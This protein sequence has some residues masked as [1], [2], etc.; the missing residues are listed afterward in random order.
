VLKKRG[1]IVETCDNGASAI[2]AVAA[3]QFDVVLMDIHMPGMDGFE[4]VRRIRADTL[5]S[6]ATVP[7]VAVTAHALPGDRSRCLA[8]GMDEYVAK[9][10]RA[11]VLIATIISAVSKRREPI[12]EVKPQIALADA[13]ITAVPSMSDSSE[14]FSKARAYVGGNEETFRRVASRL[15]VQL[16]QVVQEIR[17]GQDAAKIQAM[18]HRLSGSWSLF[19]DPPG[20]SLPAQIEQHLSTRGLDPLGALMCKN[21]SDEIE[22]LD[23]ALRRTLA[24]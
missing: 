24:L 1:A 12:G 4:A 20:Q 21:L 10:F 16:P 13:S 8:M 15:L 3:K 19:V 17:V 23:R 14:Q 7:I 6:Y 9:P 5:S 11:E 2:L 18:V 22:K